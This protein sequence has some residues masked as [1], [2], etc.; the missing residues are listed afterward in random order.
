MRWARIPTRF[1]IVSFM[2]YGSYLN[3]DTTVFS[4]N[5]IKY[6]IKKGYT[7]GIYGIYDV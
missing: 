5:I 2:F 6:G 4:T 7:T 3:T 1:F